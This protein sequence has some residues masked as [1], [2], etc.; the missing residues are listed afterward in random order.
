MRLMPLLADQAAR[1]AMSRAAGRIG[2]RD[3]AVRVLGLLD[4][5]TQR[6]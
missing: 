1:A 4:R 6:R 3:G 2:V 5:V